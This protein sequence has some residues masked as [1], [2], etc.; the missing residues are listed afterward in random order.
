MSRLFNPIA[1]VSLA[2]TSTTGN[3]AIPGTVAG[4]NRPTVRLYNAG[5][6]DVH[7]AFGTSNS[8]TAAADGTAMVIPAGV[9]E[10]FEPQRGMTYLAAI[11][12]SGTATL[13]ITRG[14]G[15]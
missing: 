15:E 6:V 8:I 9:V 13:Y 11:V 10:G 1:S 3:V 2:V 4:E 5:G 14:E 7:V 12:A